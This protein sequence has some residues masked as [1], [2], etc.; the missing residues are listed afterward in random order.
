MKLGSLVCLV[1]CF[2]S[3]LLN[4]QN[5]ISPKTTVSIRVY[6]GDTNAITPAMICITNVK[7]NHDVI[8]PHGNVILETSDNDMIFKGVEFKDT[9][10]WIGPV[11]KTNGVG[12]NK[13]RSVL[14]GVKP[15]I[16]YWDPN[17]MYQTSGD[18]SIELPAG[19]WKISIE[20]GNEYVPIVQEFDV[21]P[22][23]KELSKKYV[24][25][26]WIDLP[27]LGWYSGDVH[28]H[29]PTIKPEFK[30]YLLEMAKAEDVHLVNVLEM[31]HHKAGT[32]AMGHKHGETDFKQDGFGPEFRVNK[33]NYWI[34]SGQEDPRSRFGH[35]IGLNIQQ[36][37][38]D[39][40]T[41]DYYDLVFDNLAM[42]PGA[43]TGF[44]HFA[45]NVSWNVQNVTTGFPWWV[46]TGQIDF[47]ELLQFLK[48]NTLDY[49]DYLNLGFRI[50]AAAGSDFPWASTIGEVRTLVYTGKDFTPDSWFTALEAGHT[51]VTNGP[52]LFLNV[53]D[54]MPGDELSRSKDSI[55]K[56][57]AKAVS[58]K[59]IGIIDK[60]AVYNNDGLMV[61]SSNHNSNDSLVID[62]THKLN[63]SQWIAA[64]VYCK[65]GAVAHTSP[66]Y[67]V[68]DG[69]PT[70]SLDKGPDIIQKQI[71]S[72][73]TLIQED[74]E[75][76]DTDPGL[77]ERYNTSILFY[78]MLLKQMANELEAMQKH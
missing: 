77:I 29:H 13:D 52:A 18:F 51:F 61:E 30:Q 74:L 35:I 58:H 63:R 69:N 36:L 34:V 24:L 15:S 64:V 25:K 14:Y 11:R 28:V 70:Y 76:P 23:D 47:V 31:G 59:K 1:F 78:N 41:Y 60:I 54:G 32:D 68:V 43:V 72:I 4:S 10:N 37:V 2:M 73:E 45:W 65:N 40:S 22:G 19:K 26:R 50:T 67:V 46:T 39:S 21:K 56:I 66:I 20:H 27:A 71:S 49:Y 57:G 55:V 53:D 62:I 16:P 9:K 5:N 7:N 42:Q 48:L 75:K 12:D 38:R 6:K 8:P 44:A 33:D 3:F 17:I